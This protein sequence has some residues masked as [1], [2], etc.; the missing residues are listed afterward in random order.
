MKKKTTLLHTL[1]CAGMGFVGICCG[2]TVFKEVTFIRPAYAQSIESPGIESLGIGAI[3]RIE[4]RS[5]VIKLSH[6]QGPEGAR[7]EKV[8]VEEGQTVKAGTLLVEFS[9]LERRESELKT[10]NARLKAVE[11]RIPAYQA[12]LDDAQADYNRAIILVDSSAI[13]RSSYD[14]KRNRYLR[15]EAELSAAKQDIE[16]EKSQAHLAD[17]KI[18]QGVLKAPMNGTILKIHARPG[19]RVTENAIMEFADLRKLD[20]VAE[21]HEN[22]IPRVREKQTG[23]ILLPGS[24]K[25]YT[26]TVRQIGFMVRK[27]DLNDTDPLADKDH[28]IIE[29]RLTVDETAVADLKNQIFRQVHVRIKP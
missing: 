7:V 16:T 20:I 1:V 11:A 29:V 15:A 13:S 24:D 12:E 5:R 18:A 14:Q 10:I 28:R 4:P 23:E 9:D 8:L 21:V 27:N 3:G 26:A 19:E 25:I 17:Q 2:D 22:D 6:D